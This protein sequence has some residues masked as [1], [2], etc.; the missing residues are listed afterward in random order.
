[1]ME[2]IA[3]TM[4]INLIW[5]PKITTEREMMRISLAMPEI[6][7][8]STEVSCTTLYSSSTKAKLCNP[9]KIHIPKLANAVCQLEKN[10]EFNIVVGP[11]NI[12]DRTKRQIEMS[13]ARN[14]MVLRGPEPASTFPSS[15]SSVVLFSII[16]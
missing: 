13:G 16:S 11:S 6:E 15:M 8:V 2:I 5:S 9:P 3:P 12:M 1:M 4:L 7:K 14:I 10:G